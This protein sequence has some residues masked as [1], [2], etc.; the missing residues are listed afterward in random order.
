MIFIRLNT[1]DLLERIHRQLG[2]RLSLDHLARVTIGAQKTA[3]G[4]QALKW[5]KEGRID[6]IIEYCTKD[7]EITRDLYLYG[8]KK[9][10]VLFN[11][12]GRSDGEGAGE[13]VA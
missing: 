8:K 7:V 5:W 6:D 9:G 10:Y 3:D 12:K 4:L 11:N 2:Y 13:V 1:L